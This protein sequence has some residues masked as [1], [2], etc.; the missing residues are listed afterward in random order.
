MADVDRTPCLDVHNVVAHL[1]GT[2]PRHAGDEEP[3]GLDGRDH[4]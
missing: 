2:E 3:P 4:P 1:I